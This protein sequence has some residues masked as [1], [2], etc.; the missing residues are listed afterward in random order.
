MTLRSVRITLPVMPPPLHACF[1]NVGR[2]GRADSVRYKE[3]KRTA[4]A[5]LARSFTGS[6]GT[7][8]K[9]TFSGA[10]SVVYTVA[11][12]DKRKR[13]VDNLTKAIGDTLERNHILKDD[14]QIVDLRIR[15][16]DDD[17]EFPV[18]IDVMTHEKAKQNDVIADLIAY[19]NENKPD[20]EGRHD[21]PA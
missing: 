20:R 15:W 9:A 11:R 12:P 16:A 2:N 5:H 1:V 7:P 13:D 4:D 19:A 18:I 10:V 17:Q 3:F 6:L 14:S 8:Y 21:H